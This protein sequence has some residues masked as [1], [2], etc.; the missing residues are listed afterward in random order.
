MLPLR[1]ICSWFCLIFLFFCLECSLL[2]TSFPAYEQQR[3]L[4]RIGLMALG[5]PPDVVT[6]GG[7][8][9]GGATYHWLQFE[10]SGALQRRGR[11]GSIKA[12]DHYVQEATV[13][14]CLA[15]VAPA[16]LACVDGTC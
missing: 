6:L 11:W 1:T 10:N 15:D 4:L 12:L 7:L 2:L 3:R 14:L 5:L 13:A 16:V 8:R 9:A